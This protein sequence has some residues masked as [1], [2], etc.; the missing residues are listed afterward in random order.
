MDTDGKYMHSSITSVKFNDAIVMMYPKK[1]YRPEFV[2]LP[3]EVQS[4]L[5]LNRYMTMK[6]YQ[7]R[8]S[9]EE[10][11]A[12]MK[13]YDLKALEKVAKQMNQNVAK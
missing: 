12:R 9:N 4:R 5:S 13:V 7:K 1:E 6:N 11:M 3:Q 10:V 2:H 8:Y